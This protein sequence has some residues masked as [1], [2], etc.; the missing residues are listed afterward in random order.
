MKENQYWLTKRLS[1][2]CMVIIAAMML[3]G[4]GDDGA[5]GKDGTD[6]QGG[7]CI[8]SPRLKSGLFLDSAVQGLS[9][10]SGNLSG[11]TGQ[12]GLYNY[13]EGRTITFRIGDI[14]IGSDVPVKARMTPLDMVPGAQTYKNTTVTN[15][16]RFLQ[17]VDNDLNPDNGILVQ[18]DI[19]KNE[20]LDFTLPENDFTTAATSLISR[21]FSDGREMVS[22]EDAQQH[23]RLTLLNIPGSSVDT[24]MQ[25]LIDE[26]VQTYDI[27]GA[28]MVIITPDGLEWTG[29][30]GVSDVVNNTS[31][32]ISSK[33][34]AGSIT[35]SFTG[36][37]IAQLAQEGVLSLDDSL[38][39]CLPG[40]VPSPTAE[41]AA[42]G[43]YTGYNANNITVRNILH[44]TSGLFN[45]TDDTD[46]LMAVFTEPETRMT[47]RELADIAVSHPPLSYPENPEFNYS[48][49]NYVLLGMIIEEL[50]G[51]SWESEVRQRFVEPLGLFNTIVPETGETVIPGAYAHGYT[52]LYE[53]SGGM[54]GQ[55]NILVDYSVLEPSLT[56]AAGNI[57]SAPADMA[58]WIKA[59]AEG[60]LFDA[61]NQNMVMTDMYPMEAIPIEYGYGIAKN[62]TYGLIGH[63]GQII[64][65]DVAMQYHLETR[66]AIAVS[67][68]RNLPE[69]NIQNAIL[70][71]A[72]A[73]LLDQTGS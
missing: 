32:T 29:R 62:L 18:E 3:F 50:T 39:T 48:E 2:F 19:G 54:A 22:V 33:F 25:Q 64:G 9:Y 20:T 56:W 53:Y 13:E 42:S 11:L 41:E 43:E 12:D 28:I 61:D 52:D 49:T 51:N 40:V 23:F 30:S 27:P 16:L 45:F 35:K 66:T 7:V 37:I 6:G 46:F 65:Y 14:A 57:I 31:L 5:D 1:C 69:E 58:Q 10:V 59:I 21:M 68:N 73:I 24:D 4:C 15:I 26:T 72:L 60:K 47:P 36:M 8:E 55:E 17:T 44:H 38:E 70:F 71:E 34:R 67:S 63:K